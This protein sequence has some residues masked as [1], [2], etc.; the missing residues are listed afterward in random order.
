[1]IPILTAMTEWE[2]GV[3]KFNEHWGTNPILKY[4]IKEGY[5]MAMDRFE[6][7]KDANK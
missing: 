3:D 5:D 2:M 6:F 4:Y 7:L 1:M